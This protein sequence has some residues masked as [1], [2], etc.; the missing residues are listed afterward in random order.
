MFTAGAD[1]LF[2][3]RSLDIDILGPPGGPDNI[4]RVAKGEADFC[5]TSVHHYLTA[6]DLWG[7]L[8]ARFAGV[9]VQRSPLA[10]LVGEDSAIVEPG[11]LAG[12]RVA[13][14]AGPLVDEFVYTL[15]QLGVEPPVVQDLDSD[16]ARAALAHGS[17]DAIVGFVDGLPRARRLVGKPLRS[18]ALGLEVYASGLVAGDHVDRDAVA[19]MRSAMVAALAAQRDDPGRG[20][21]ELCERYP[22]TVPDEAV[23]GWRL[24]EPYVFAGPEPLAMERSRWLDTLAHLTRARGLPGVSLDS[25]CR[26]E[27]LAGGAERASDVAGVH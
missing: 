5:L 23:E 19:R 14:K 2:A 13:G 24:V 9:V 16:A 22:D 10:A 12:C 11:N 7:D 25:V 18:V 6:R 27:F 17:V 8:A 26:T 1:G 4:L 21:A 15:E 3:S 20:L